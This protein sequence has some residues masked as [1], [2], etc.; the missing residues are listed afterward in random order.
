MGKTQIIDVY[1]STVYKKN[2]GN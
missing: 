2:F 1:V